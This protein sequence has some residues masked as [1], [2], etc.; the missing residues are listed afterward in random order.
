MKLNIERYLNIYCIVMLLNFLSITAFGNY[1]KILDLLVPGF[2]IIIIIIYFRE[3]I[4]KI[5]LNKELLKILPFICFVILNA[6]IIDFKY[7]VQLIQIIL[8]FFILLFFYNIGV[9]KKMK[10]NSKLVN[11][12]V[13][14]MVLTVGFINLSKTNKISWIMEHS[15]AFGLFNLLL[16]FFYE[17]SN[18][19]PKNIFQF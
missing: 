15:N 8:I 14:L 16:Y 9:D 10:L 19:K 5:K 1:F 18:K 12:L 7:I 6:R 4:L 17:L 11:F 3:N 13:Y 2:V